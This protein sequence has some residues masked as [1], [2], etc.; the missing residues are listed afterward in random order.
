MK[1][2]VVGCGAYMTSGYGCPG[3]WRCLK[4]ASRGEWE[5]EEHADVVVFVRCECPGRATVN[6][7][8]L[9]LKQADTKP[10]AVHL[11]SC[12]VDAAPPCPYATMDEWAR[13]IEE[14]IGVPVHQRTHDYH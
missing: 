3:E 2:A 13:M 5:F 10:D 8:A 4:A 1:V 9:A 14:K 6:N 12:M 11:S 7:L